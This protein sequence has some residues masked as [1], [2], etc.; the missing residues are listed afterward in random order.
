MSKSSITT[1]RTGTEGVA[2]PGRVTKARKEH[3]RSTERDVQ[4][5]AA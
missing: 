5:N 3:G 1:K 2:T 4:P